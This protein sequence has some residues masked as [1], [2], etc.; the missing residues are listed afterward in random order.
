MFP[1]LTRC[2][3]QT[4]GS[5]GKVQEDS[6]LCVL[7][8]NIISE[9]IFI[10]LWFWYFLLLAIAVPNLVLVLLMALRSIRIRSYFLTMAVFSRQVRRYVYKSSSLR[11]EIESM[12]FGKFLFIYLLGQNVDYFTY[13]VQHNDFSASFPPEKPRYL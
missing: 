9:K 11:G 5:G 1:R 10:F 7:A 12:P 6:S 8:P 3:F 13:K 4:F 2:A